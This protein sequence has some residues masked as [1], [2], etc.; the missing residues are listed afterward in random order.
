MKSITK[1]LLLIGVLAT[2]IVSL[3][4]CSADK[5]TKNDCCSFNI[6]SIKDLQGNIV[7]TIG[8]NQIENNVFTG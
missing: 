2:A 3:S 5:K 1:K 4:A 6:I 7:K 8:Y